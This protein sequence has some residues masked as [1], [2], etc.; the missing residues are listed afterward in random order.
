MVPNQAR[1][2]ADIRR[3]LLIIIHANLKMDGFLSVRR[4]Q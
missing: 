2:H 4:S 1:D 3:M